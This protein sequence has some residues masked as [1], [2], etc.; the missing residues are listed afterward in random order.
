MTIVWGD[1]DDVAKARELFERMHGKPYPEPAGDE[2]DVF[3]A[4]AT[5]I[6]WPATWAAGGLDFK[7]RALCTV[8]AL[9]DSGRPQV[10]GHIKAAL[11]A[12]WSRQD[13]ADLITH[14]AFYTGFPS[15]G[16]AMRAAKEVFAE[17][18]QESAH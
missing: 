1:P 12:G 16:N 7:T 3:N 6:Q 5:D 4:L 13:I 10:R 9:V 8:A 15:A 14:I 18:D 11:A 2:F 17:I